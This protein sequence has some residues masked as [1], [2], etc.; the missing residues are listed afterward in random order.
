MDHTEIIRTVECPKCRLK[1]LAGTKFCADCG[2]PLVSGVPLTCT[3]C[4]TE[5]PPGTKFCGN[6]GAS[7]E[8]N[9]ESDPDIHLLQRALKGRYVVQKSLG[10]GGF[11]RVFLALHEG[12][13]RK[14]VIKLLGA[15]QSRSEDI[16]R[17]FLQEAQAIAKLSHPNIIEIKDVA[18]FEGRPYY[19]MSYRE[20]GSLEDLLQKEKKLSPERAI[21]L[22]K[23]ILSALSEIHAKGIIHRDIKPDNVLLGDK[24]EAILIDFGIA[25]V[26]EDSTL[27]P[28]TGT[29]MTIGTVTYMSP[30]QLEGKSIDSRSDLYSTGI[31][32]YELLVGEP[33]FQGSLPSLILK[34]T[35]EEVPGITDKLN[36][37]KF[38][39]NLEYVIKKACEK[40][41][42]DRFGNAM[43]MRDAFGLETTEIPILQKKKPK[44]VVQEPKGNLGKI[45]GGIAALLAVVGIGFGGMVL[46][47]PKSNVYITSDPSGATVLNDTSGQVLGTTPYEELKTTG[48]T[49]PYLLKLKNFRDVKLE[50]KLK[51]KDDTQNKEVKLTD[52]RNVSLESEPAGVSITG[53]GVEGETTPYYGEL[54]TGKYDLTFSKDGYYSEKLSF[55]IGKEGNRIEKKVKLLDIRNVSIDSEPTGATLSGGLGSGKTTPFLEEVKPGKY[56]ATISKD[57]YHEEKISFS[58]GTPKDRY[59][60]KIKL[61]TNQEFADLEKKKAECEKQGMDFLEG[62]CRKKPDWSPYM[63]EMNWD[64]ASA[65]CRSIG[66]RL[67]T[68]DELKA[69]YNAGI[70]KSW[71]KDGYYYWSSTPYDAERY[72]EFSVDVGNTNDIH[73][74]YDRSVRCRR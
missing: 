19:I 12:L 33:P 72:Y 62:E 5:N 59:E 69:A 21:E 13:K 20:G 64:S 40:K 43:E 10:E 31:L 48:G 52:L 32:L 22:C 37:H 53:L 8:L 9:V 51:D 56:E 67:P 17:R 41:A 7:F 39:P 34:H 23:G 45:L 28:K 38:A 65:K 25:R 73:R 18:E 58:L 49:Y 68:I 3:K 54:K 66:M 29:G 1:N 74:Y 50:I 57:G 6:C 36:N 14:D 46:M 2:T 61:M 4:G 60:K 44:P 35:T 55:I 70:T 27:K 15:D 42:E 63:G 30:E 71:Q 47:K 24:G 11:G 16:K 26:E